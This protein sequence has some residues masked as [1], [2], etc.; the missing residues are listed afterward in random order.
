MVKSSFLCDELADTTGLLDL[1]LSILAEETGADDD[2]DLR[3]A[4]LAENLAVAEGKEVEDGCGVTGLASDELLALL[5]RDK[6]PKLRMKMIS[7]RTSSIYVSVFDSLP[8]RG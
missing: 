4:T 8:S 1:A 3:D 5:E 2:W 6:G 7:P